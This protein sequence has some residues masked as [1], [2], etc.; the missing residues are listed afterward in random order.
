MRRIA[1][2]CGPEPALVRQ[3]VEAYRAGYPADGIWALSA[4]EE[5][6]RDV[7]DELMSEPGLS[8]RLI[9]VHSAEKLADAVLMTMLAEGGPEGG[10]VL[11][12]S[13][14]DDFTRIESDGKK[15]LAPHLAVLQAHRHGQLI[16]CCAPGRRED[17]VAMVA[18]WWPGAGLNLG[19]EVLTLC[20]GSLTRAWE[21][22]DKAVRAHLPPVAR[23]VQMVCLPE[24]GDSFADALIAGNKAGALAAAR[25]A[26][27]T[28]V[29]AGLGL[30]ASRLSMLAAIADA[31]RTGAEVSDLPGRT[32]ID[33]YLLHLLTPHAAAYGADRVARCRE[34]LAMAESAWR[35]GADTGVA[36][37]VISLWLGVVESMYRIYAPQWLTFYTSM[38]T[39]DEGRT[40]C[41]GAFV[42]YQGRVH[43]DDWRIET[44]ANSYGR[45]F[46]QLRVPNC[47]GEWVD[48][49]LAERQAGEHTGHP[50][51]I[52]RRGSREEQ[53]L[54]A[55]GTRRL[56]RE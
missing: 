33:R 14:E 5:T 2:V 52:V 35:A 44:P 56:R 55:Y 16:R 22:C 18:S 31:L 38:R 15:V 13:A 47:E 1:W 42:K 30:L 17:Q 25:A 50:H 3:V 37:I 11:F 23:S 48:R 7:R 32:R 39:G 53:E 27:R 43:E 10:C 29:G 49:D 24:P 51:Q 26:R 28:E 40:E 8:A 45:S 6:S 19:H 36:E 12:V 41:F 46:L 54:L 4:A 34:V 21:A 20:G 9:I